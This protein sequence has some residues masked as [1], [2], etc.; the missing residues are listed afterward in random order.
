MIDEVIDS[1]LKTEQEADAIVK[2]AELRAAQ[3]NA[4]ASSEI[5]ALDKDYTQKTKIEIDD[6]LASARRE[7]DQKAASIMRASE[8]ESEGIR[9][10]AQKNSKAAIERVVNAALKGK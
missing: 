5:D 7:A 6:K 10:K 1:I 2:E 4:S 3:I 9:A 8:A